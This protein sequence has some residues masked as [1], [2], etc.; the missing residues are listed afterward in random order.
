MTFFSLL[1]FLGLLSLFQ[2]H[3]CVLEEV[4][5]DRTNS[6]HADSLRVS[7]VEITNQV[8]KGLHCKEIFPEGARGPPGVLLVSLHGVKEE[9]SLKGNSRKDDSREQKALRNI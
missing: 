1:E 2:A 6:S 8:G 4:P 7:L 5:R 9:R 3:S